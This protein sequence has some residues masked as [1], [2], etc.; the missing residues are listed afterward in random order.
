MAHN[1]SWEDNISSN[2]QAKCP[3]SKEKKV[4]KGSYKKQPSALVLIHNKQV[5]TILFSF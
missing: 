2:K 1:P 3:K 4:N 5:Q